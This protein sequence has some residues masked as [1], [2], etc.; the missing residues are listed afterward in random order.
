MKQ[1]TNYNQSPDDFPLT[2]E[3]WHAAEEILLGDVRK[4]FSLSAAAKEIGVSR[5][6]LVR[7]IERSRLRL[8]SDPPWSHSIHM[9]YD[10]R[11]SIIADRLEDLAWKKALG[12][13]FID[14]DGEEVTVPGDTRVLM[15][16]LGVH[17]KRYKTTQSKKDIPDDT[18]AET[19][20]RKLNA[21][22]HM[23]RINQ[24]EE[25]KKREQSSG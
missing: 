2:Q 12:T 25:R 9:I 19:I 21:T 10:Q 23:D 3:Q 14:E 8:A 15:A 11:E 13:T 4:H 18:D 22:V 6:V 16:M 1:S 17:D 24:I 20:R 7:A 5:A